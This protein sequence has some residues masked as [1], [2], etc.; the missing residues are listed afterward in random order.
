MILNSNSQSLLWENIDLLRSSL[1]TG[2]ESIFQNL[3]APTAAVSAKRETKTVPDANNN[4]PT[5]IESFRLEPIS[6]MERKGPGAKTTKT[7]RT[8]ATNPGSGM[9]PVGNKQVIAPPATPYSSPNQVA[10]NLQEYSMSVANRDLE[11]LQKEIK[12]LEIEAARIA[13]ETDDLAKQNQEAGGE[14]ESEETETAALP[15]LPVAK[16]FTMSEVDHQINSGFF[17]DGKE[18]DR[19]VIIDYVTNR[20]YI[21]TTDL[22]SKY[23]LPEFLFLDVPNSTYAARACGHFITDQVAKDLKKLEQLVSGSP[24]TKREHVLRECDKSTYDVRGILVP[25]QPEFYGKH[26]MNQEK[27]DCPVIYDS[28]DGEFPVQEINAKFRLR[29]ARRGTN[30]E[31][32]LTHNFMNGLTC[33]RGI[34][35]FIPIMEKESP[36]GQFWGSCRG[37][38][39]LARIGDS[40]NSRG[41]DAWCREIA[42]HHGVFRGNSPEQMGFT[43]SCHGHL[44]PFPSQAVHASNHTAST[45]ATFESPPKPKETPKENSK[46]VG[47][48]SKMAHAKKK[49]STPKKKTP[50]TIAKTKRG[51]IKKRTKK[52]VPVLVRAESM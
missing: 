39:G 25:C 16:L 37:V 20:S 23:S 50:K 49:E 19:N 14:A 4:S 29:Y 22:T 28:T 32:M 45:A 7:A 1:D 31:K 10:N 18:L 36:A 47:W 34:L 8:A 13:K 27:N 6:E 3:E 21:Y 46:K 40:I 24:T 42:K 38:V 5:G 41:I 26:L 12:D 51:P 15:G 52:V 9:S 30:L 43:A 17:V 11:K 33:K 44:G 2:T 35:V 48:K